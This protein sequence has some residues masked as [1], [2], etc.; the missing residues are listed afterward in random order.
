MH[1]SH[2][3]YTVLLAS[4][5]LLLAVRL[6]TEKS[7]YGHMAT[8]FCTGLTVIAALCSTQKH[9][10]V[11]ALMLAVPVLVLTTWARF[12]PLETARITFVLIRGF[13]SVFMGYM[14]VAILLDLLDQREI[15]RDTLV[16]TFCGYALIG[17][18]FTE[19]Y[20]WIDLIAPD[21][22]SAVGNGPQGMENDVG[23][24]HLVYFS[25]VTLS[26][27]GYG[28]VLPVNKVARI[29]ACLEA[30]FGQFYLAILVAGLVSIRV[31]QVAAAKSTSSDNRA[32]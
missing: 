18:I 2:W 1:Y 16:G 14:T 19:L 30:I 21:S 20:C 27:L 15:T 29:L 31:G 23:W 4:M 25:F 26:T 7:P 32:K 6:T 13:M 3:K 12:E 5:F 17:A 10:R 11:G 28:D 8:D 24:N 9:L 22:F